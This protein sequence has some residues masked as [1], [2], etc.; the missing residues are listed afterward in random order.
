MRALVTG[1]AGFIGSHLVERL[2]REGW[3]VRVLD[4]LSTGRRA[5]LAAV[6]ADVELVEG[7]VRDPGTVRR[8]VAGADAVAH[9]AAL[10][11][12]ARSVAD[13][14][15]THEVN[16]TGTL[17]VLLAARD[18]GVARVVVASS[19]SVYGDTP[20]LPLHEA[21]APQP[22]SPYAVSKLAAERYAAVFAALYG[23]ET[24]GLR[25][26]NV[27]GPRQDPASPYAAV[28]PRFVRALLAGEPPTIY[29]D[30]EQGRDFTYVA[31]AVEATALA[32]RAPRLAGEAVNVACGR[33]T[34]VNALAREVAAL[35]GVTVAPLHAPPR[36][37]DV[38]DSLADLAR[39]RTLLGYAP[40][41]DVV[42]G[43]RRTVAWYRNGGAAWA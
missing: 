34:T 6:A 5:N 15:R 29:G 4:D 42:E 40:Q 18:A 35:T 36:P 2:L 7:D 8:A 9:L 22:R 24:V 28:V 21:L 12:V 26:F 10:S 16:A 31:N 43:L 11:S 25:Y 17:H 13:P 41:V 14:L 1:G 32:L 20:V 23:L 19:S 38:R 33:R 30:G 39:A 37:G 3:A 27:F